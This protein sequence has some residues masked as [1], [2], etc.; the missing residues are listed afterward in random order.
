[1][2]MYFAFKLAPATQEKMD[3]LLSNLDAGVS[4]PQYALHEKLSVELVDEILK[5][6]VEGLLN[7]GPRESSGVLQTFL[8]ILKSTSHMLVKQ[9]LG[10]ESNAQINKNAKYLR[11]HAVVLNGEKRFGFAFSDDM[12]AKFDAYFSAVERD[13]GDVLKPQILA[14][15]LEFAEAAMKSFLDEFVQPMELGFIKRKAVDIGRATMHKGMTVAMTKMVPT[16]GHNQLKAFV[17]YYREIMIV[18]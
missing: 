1:M 12:A 13:E 15:M 3:L 10:K 2:T 4:E 5:N 11:D 9:L 7:I 16:L 17:Q 6:L 14:L 18:A 8:S